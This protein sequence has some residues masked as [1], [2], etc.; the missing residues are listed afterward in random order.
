[1]ERELVIGSVTGTLDPTEAGDGSSGNLNRQRARQPTREAKKSFRPIQCVVKSDEC[2]S[3]LKTTICILIRAPQGSSGNA[4]RDSGARH[5]RG[6][7]GTGGRTPQRACCPCAGTKLIHISFWVK[8]LSI[9]N[10]GNIHS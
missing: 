2:G 8:L 5:H 9:G 3:V 4:G 7:P 6:R 1:M 10:H